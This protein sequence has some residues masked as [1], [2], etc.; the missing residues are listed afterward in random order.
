[1]ILNS[2]KITTHG[3][4][5][6]LFVRVLWP[7]FYFQHFQV[8]KFQ[9]RLFRNAQGLGS[10]EHFFHKSPKKLTLT[11]KCFESSFMVSSILSLKRSS[12]EHCFL[13]SCM[14]MHKTVCCFCVRMRLWLSRKFFIFK[15][16]FFIV[17]CHHSLQYQHSPF[18]FPNLIFK[19]EI[20]FLSVISQDLLNY[21]LNN[22]VVFYFFFEFFQL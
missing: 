20:P 14:C 13:I 7:S 12:Q 17:L 19:S 18:A 15:T 4:F 16:D 5:L 21:I 22:Y 11:W 10:L 3:L 8:T 2:I 6:F 9:V 1:M